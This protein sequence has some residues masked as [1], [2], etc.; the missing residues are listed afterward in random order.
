[1]TVALAGWAGGEALWIFYDRVLDRVPFPSLADLGYLLF[2]LG[3]GVA[4]ALYPTGYSGQRQTRYVL[5]GLI[6][7]FALFEISWVL[8]LRDA[9]DAGG[10][11]ALALGLALTYPIADIAI[12]TIGILAL[13]RARP[14][15]RRTLAMLTGAMVL[16]AVADCAF[17]YLAAH[18]IY[19]SG[20]IIDIGWVAAFVTFGMAG[21]IDRQAP[22]A[23]LVSSQPPSRSSLWLPYI[24]L[25]LAALVCIPAYIGTPG[26]GP[27]FMS[28]TLLMAAVM[29]RQFVVV[30]QN[31]QL[32]TMVADQALRDTLTGLA[33]RD[34]FN[35]RLMHAVQ[36]HENDNQSVAVLSMD[37]DDFKLVNDSLGHP[38]GDE[39]LTQAAERLLGCVRPSDTVAR[40]GGDEFAVLMEGLPELSRLV[41]HR[42]VSAFEEPFL[43]D[44]QQ[45]LMRPSV[46][47]AVASSAD[48]E[49]SAELLLKQADVA[50]YS[51]KR[52]KSGGLHTFTPDMALADLNNIELPTD[53]SESAERGAAV[54]L[55]GE[56]RHAIDHRDLTVFYQPKFDLRSGSVV[57]VEA[58]V[59]WPHRKR[60]LLGPA[61]FLPLVRK[62]GLMRAVTDLVLTQAL[63]DAAEWHRMGVGVPIAVNVFAPSL[64]DL[65]LP[66]HIASALGMRGLSPEDL[67]IEITEDFLLDNI[68][69]TRSVLERL[70]QRGIRIAI[71]DFGS[72][73]S[74]LWY[75]REL[76][77]DEVK[78]DRHFIAPIRVDP[79]AAAVVRGVVDLA[80]VL[81]VTTVAEGVENAETAERLREFGCEVAQG[82]YYSPPVSAAAMMNMLASGHPSRRQEPL[83]DLDANDL[84][85]QAA[86]KS[87]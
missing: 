79:R 40:V 68:D 54:R 32:L 49:L 45:L 24:P 39:L 86:A 69:R 56:L 52:S 42:V 64:G 6:V 70:R 47:L 43:I 28:S 16:M 84:Q 4:I 8:L 76:A 17:A 81:G 11:S 80:H 36:L 50:M 2:P 1:M 25:G 72:G 3:T 53:A 48:P 21:L 37:L 34:L 83:E 41:A 62:R 18:N 59:R 15:A 82:Y 55:L 73:Y 9:F 14:W 27:I 33:N 77:I 12:I 35:D 61:H 66:T 57:G 63:D 65:D 71:D 19:Y 22:E 51:A 58:L 20:H 29:A 10:T 38:A 13:A 78:L 5:D 23:E 26:L 44:G 7:A 67:T 87:N 60:G 75:L 74:A 85:E 46:G 31:Q 30:R